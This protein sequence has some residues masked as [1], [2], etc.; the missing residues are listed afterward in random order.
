M[1]D[2]IRLSISTAD[3]GGFD[4]QVSYVNLPTPD[5]SLGILRGHAPMLCAVGQ[6]SVRYT[7]DGQTGSVRVGPGVATVAD[8]EVLLLVKEII[9]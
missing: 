6:G 3:G 5:G 8:N 1:A 9:E 2:S 4:K 7:A